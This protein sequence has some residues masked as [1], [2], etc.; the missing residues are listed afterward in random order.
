[1]LQAVTTLRTL[2]LP[3]GRAIPALGQGSVA[4]GD[5]PEKRREEVAALRLGLDLGLVLIDTAEM[6]A[7]GGAEQVVG[8]AIEGR[9]DE[10]FLTSKV[11]PDH[12]T[13]KGTIAACERS[14]KRLKTDYLPVLF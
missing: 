6:Y 10:V 12:A 14:L 8:E 7:D 9:R 4:T 3:T 1:M 13:R 11:L 5:D 2:R